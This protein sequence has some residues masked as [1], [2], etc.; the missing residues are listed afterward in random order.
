MPDSSDTSQDSVN[1]N[2]AANQKIVVRMDNV[3]NRV[4][5][6]LS[7]LAVIG[8]AS[9][10]FLYQR[11]MASFII[12]L[13]LLMAM[14]VAKVLMKQGQVRLSGILVISSVWIIFTFMIL[15]GGGLENINVVFFVS[16][17]VV[18][19]LLFG[20]RA[21]LWVAG[22]G[23]TMGLALALMAIFDRL[24]AQYFM[25]S[26]FGN[27]AELVLALVLTASTLNI[28]LRER[29]NAL[30]IANKQFSDRLEAEKAL[31]EIEIRNRSF[32]EAIP[33]LMFIF[34]RDGI[35]LDYHAA[36]KNVPA[37]DPGRFLGKSIRDMLPADLVE[38]L[39]YSF[40]KA[41]ETK[42]T[43]VI[44]H[45]LEMPGGRRHFEARVT[46]MDD[47]RQLTI[48]RDITERKI[49]EEALQ[50]AEIRFIQV[51]E[52]IGE[53]IWEVDS[54]GL[55]QYCSPA[56]ERILGYP[57][58]EMIGKKHFFD[59]FTPDVKEKLKEEACAV[60]REKRSFQNFINP[61]LH[62]NGDVVIL[63]TS[64]TP[65]VDDRGNLL[66]YRGSDTDI[67]ERKRA[68]DTLKES[69]ANYRQ[70]FENSPVAIYRI[71]FKTGKI[72]KANDVFFR[73]LGCNREDLSS[74]SIYD[75]LS[76]S[77]KKLFLERL[78]KM[79]RGEKVPEAVEY[80][81]FDATGTPRFVHLQNKNTY[82]DQGYI[83]A[84]DVVAHDVTERRRA[85]NELRESE[86]KFRSLIEHALNCILILDL[87]GTIL[88]VN[89]A[90]AQTIE[91][92]D[93]ESL[94]GRNVME[95]IAEESVE[96]VAKDFL[97][98]QQ[99]H[100]GYLAQY[101]LR[102]LRGQRVYVESVGK[103]I[104]YEGK[105]AVLA[106]LLD[107]TKRI[108]AEEEQKILRDQLTQA[109]KM[110]SVGRL[111]G[112]VAHDFN[113]MLSVII[114]N[115]EMAMHKVRRT[116]PLYRTLQQI[117]NAGNRSADLTRQL[118][119]FARKQTVSPKVL[120]LN[121]TV[122]GML[123]MLQ[124]LI[125]EDIA[126][127]WH[128]GH[129]LWKVRIDPSQIDQLLANLT[130]NARDAIESTGRIVIETSNELCDDAFC[131]GRVEC[132]PGEYVMLAVTDNGQGMGKET[133]SNIFEPF[134]TTKKEGQGTG[135]GLATVYGI[136]KQN[137]GFIEVHSEPQQG[138][139][140]KIYLPRHMDENGETADDTLLQEIRG[141]TETILIAEDEESVLN[142]SREMLESLGY[143]VL[144]AR[145]ADLAILL[146][147]KY[148][149]NIDL[150][151]TDVV[152][153]DM[154]GKELTERI[155]AIKPGLRCLYMS[156]YTADV[157]ARQ[158]ILEEGIQFIP[159]P[160]SLRD[161][162]SKVRAMLD[163]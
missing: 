53:L 23:I 99:G 92:D 162:A 126:L 9:T 100:D 10:P 41:Q 42:Q 158:G 138:A 106:S 112:G 90:T 130:V 128:P 24:P 50:N 136:V 47:L 6:I 3:L 49:T 27:L 113:N 132:I 125:G 61:N 40:E 150:L 120:D 127:I 78:E 151:L 15:L 131:T 65:I 122:A 93:A 137:G 89:H 97:E 28:A 29:S 38:K 141:G 110:E 75:R 91:A 39:L 33:D 19:G 74:F 52:N 7:I 116:D 51:T 45:V 101:H 26:P 77:S 149:G 31:R 86:A 96:D 160:F 69:E 63:E 119:A 161:L 103:L 133:L 55:Y 58:E 48:V 11:K 20:E 37:L 102:S 139:T 44:E 8:L 107:V 14:L 156:G 155:R 17:T 2:S 115:T 142:L 104:T 18:A 153:P 46:A 13:V 71:D 21:T 81:I 1:N 4:I 62:K 152:M 118:L 159:K 5:L 25:R 67:T 72:L 36:D 66:G 16:L 80:E 94:V 30:D 59:F 134:F 79:W 124:R 148:T 68:E 12:I 22:A 95:F 123:K 54:D 143:K 144:M 109:Q 56:V 108:Q 82:D 57:P 87:K 111:A 114:G 105:Q 98:L 157:I 145:N 76:E 64:G 83:V 135:L 154:N 163:R 43:Q 60:F 73:Y 32:L 146:F 85:E 147:K 35:F 129:T 70:L 88:F 117:M 140:F 121:D 84:S 34:S